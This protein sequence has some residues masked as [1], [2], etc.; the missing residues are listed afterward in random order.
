[1]HKDGNHFGTPTKSDMEYLEHGDCERKAQHFFLYCG[2]WNDAHMTVMWDE[3]SQEWP[4]PP[5]DGIDFF[6]GEK[7]EINEIKYLLFNECLTV[8]FALACQFD[9]KEEGLKME[10]ETIIQGILKR[11]QQQPSMIGSKE[12]SKILEAEL[13]IKGT[14]GADTQQCILKDVS[15][16]RLS[17]QRT[18]AIAR[19]ESDEYRNAYHE[20]VNTLWQKSD[21]Q[22]WITAPIRD[23]KDEFQLF[24]KR[25][26]DAIA[27]AS[28]MVMESSD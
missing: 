21:P 14:K 2:W 24:E 3:L 8:E 1:M 23:F 26:S 5:S 20:V 9:K 11:R 17:Q 22:E 15:L 19:L 13:G 12:Q 6:A 25:F 28:T 7:L 27:E 4:P 16:S 18:S 10:R